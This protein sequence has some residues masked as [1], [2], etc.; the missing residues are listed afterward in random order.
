M[1]IYV[2]SPQ[3]LE[4]QRGTRKALTFN[5]IRWENS[6]HYD[7]VKGYRVMGGLITPPTV[8]VGGKSFTRYVQTAFVSPSEAYLIYNAV[9]D[10]GWPEL[11]KVELLLPA[12]VA[13]RSLMIT[14]VTAAFVAPLLSQ[15][16]AAEN[17]SITAQIEAEIGG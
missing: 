9:K 12:D 3:V 5:V 10:A 1:N 17:Q 13:C 4:I 15:L 14:D 8:P 2:D 11:G 16:L 7:V 6:T